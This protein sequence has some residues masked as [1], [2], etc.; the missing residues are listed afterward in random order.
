MLLTDHALSRRCVGCGLAFGIASA[1]WIVL[2]HRHPVVALQYH[3]PLAVL[4]ATFAAWMVLAPR[5][6][7]RGA[8]WVPTLMALATVYGRM[9]HDWP[10]S[11]HGVLGAY[12]A[13]VAPWRWLRVLSACVLPQAVF[14]KLLIDTDPGDVAVGAVV[15]VALGWV[16]RRSTSVDGGPSAAPSPPR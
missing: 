3:V 8:L 4:F 11:G 12:L 10:T 7:P 1:T 2:S 5:R 13:L 16:A 15:G 9:V 6:A 14:T